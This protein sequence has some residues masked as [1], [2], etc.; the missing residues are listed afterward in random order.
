MSDTLFLF[1]ANASDGKS[2]DKTLWK[3][4]MKKKYNQ[5]LERFY[6]LGG[7]II[8]EIRLLPDIPDIKSNNFCRCLVV[9]RAFNNSNSSFDTR[10]FTGTSKFLQIMDILI[11]VQNFRLK[12]S[13]F[14]F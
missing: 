4:L 7:P 8:Q 3:R 1:Y 2:I 14:R 12:Y 9:Q 5:S 11:L 10:F 13:Y 6:L